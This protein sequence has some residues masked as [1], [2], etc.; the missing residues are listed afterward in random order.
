MKYT[1]ITA[2]LVSSAHAVELTPA[3]WDAATAGK[4]V[5][6]KFFA[7]WCGHCKSMK[8]D[9][10][11]LMEEFGTS[12]TQLVADVDCT[13]EGQAICDEQGVQGFPTLKWYVKKKRRKK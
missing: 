12:A 4:T 1:L 6:I 11:K 10:D 3:T 2:V 5:F 9:W 13:G 7:P 8:P